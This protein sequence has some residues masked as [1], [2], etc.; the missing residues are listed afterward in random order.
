MRKIRMILMLKML[1][2]V[3]MML[4]MT[5]MATTITMKMSKMLV[6]MV[7]MLRMMVMA[8]TITM[9]TSRDFTRTNIEALRVQQLFGAPL[10]SQDSE[11]L[12]EVQNSQISQVLT[13]LEM[14]YGNKVDLL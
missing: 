2:L 1:V 13:E 8:T 10:G 9:M 6:L 7:M 12:L 5:V 3:M 11:D 4:R 14:M